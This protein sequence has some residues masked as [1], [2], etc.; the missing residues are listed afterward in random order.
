MDGTQCMAL[1]QPKGLN[2]VKAYLLRRG[3]SHMCRVWRG[4][5][6]AD[7]SDDNW[8]REWY[9]LLP[10]THPQTSKQDNGIELR[11]VMEHMY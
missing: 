6:P 5:G 10:K 3:R 11:I 4:L 7:E 1:G 2:E 9:S 8:E